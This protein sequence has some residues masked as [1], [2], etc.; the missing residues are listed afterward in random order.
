MIDKSIYDAAHNGDVDKV[1]EWLKTHRDQLSQ[2]ISDGFTLLHVASAFGRERLVAHL[3]DLGA[4]VNAD[5]KNDARE[6]P[7]HLAVVHRDG[8]VA[9]RIADR[10]IA[11]GAELNARQ[12]GGL[13]PL[14]HAVSRALNPEMTASKTVVEILILAGA[15]PFLKDDQGK[16]AM[17]LVNESDAMSADTKEELKTIMKRAHHLPTEVEV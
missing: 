17:S 5:A 12:A 13:T 15:D 10:L 2:P 11:N 4:I 3:L 14:H 9:A 16:S 7:L 8:A 6:T 1:E